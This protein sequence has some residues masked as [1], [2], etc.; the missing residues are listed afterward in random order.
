M[1]LSFFMQAL[2]NRFLPHPL[3]ALLLVAAL[4]SCKPLPEDSGA[5]K[6]TSPG[7]VVPS[8][9]LV[10]PLPPAAPG[11]GLV[12]CLAS[13]ADPH[14]RVQFNL[15]SENVRKVPGAGLEVRDAAAN[16][17]TQRDQL[18]Q[19]LAKPPAVVLIRPVDA[20]AIKTQI[21]ELRAAGA[22][23]IGLDA[24]L[25][26][27]VCDTVVFCDQRK[28]GKLAGEAVVTALQRKAADEGRT[29]VSGRVAQLRGSDA[30]PDCT[31]RSE[32]FLEALKAQPGI[33]LVHDAP[34]D[35]DRAKGGA[36]F[37]EAATLQKQID[38][39]FAHN[40]LMAQGASTAATELQMRESLLIVGADGISGPGAGLEMLRNSEL[41]A[42]VHQPL[43]VD[44]AW[45]LVERWWKDPAF[46]PKASY[47]IE[48]V[49]FTPK[50]LAELEKK[51][52]PAP[53]L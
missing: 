41:D 49:L 14:Q 47:E 43:L 40:D 52:L 13:L 26:A 33:V 42:T 4:T 5:A 31:A 10:A 36:R 1:R 20:A 2:A 50:N 3:A 38:V 46:K 17:T 23:V 12:L 44:F 53:S 25:G 11:K 8:A 24:S 7:L 34:A 35:W 18:Q 45:R 22:K 19:L 6:E 39:V 15:L 37:K 27:G 48:P 32:G 9:P 30:H 51:G 21:D 16:A 29:D 28:I